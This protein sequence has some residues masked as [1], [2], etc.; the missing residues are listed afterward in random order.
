MDPSFEDF[1]RSEYAKVFRGALAFCG[2]PEVAREST[3]EAF[4]RAFARYKRLSHAPWAGGWVMT[5][6]MNLCRRALKDRDTE[7]TTEP[8][9][10]STGSEVRLDVTRALA[11]LPYRQR[12]A[13]VLFYIGDLALPAVAE[14]MGLSEGAVRSHL[15]RARSSLRK[16]LEVEQDA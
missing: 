2:R 10:V 16:R 14:S 11:T 3:Q 12:Q 7:P 4:A 5:T 13:A 6:A 8:S 9:S 1:Y 15:A